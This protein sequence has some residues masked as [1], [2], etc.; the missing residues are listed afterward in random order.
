MSGRIRFAT[1]WVLAGLGAF[2]AAPA[3]AQEPPPVLTGSVLYRVTLLRAAGGKYDDLLAEVRRQVSATGGLAVRHSQGDQWDFVWLTPV[4]PASATG[5]AA[6][7]SPFSE[8]AVAWQEDLLVR[9]PALDALPGFLAAG[10]Y[11]FEMFDA[12]PGK[13]DELVRER[14]M[15]N[16]YLAGVGRP[17]NLIF[18]REF[19][20]AWDAFTIGAYRDWRHYAERELVTPA[21]A[22]AAAVAAG[23]S[24]EQAIGPYMRSL[25]LAHHDTLGGPIR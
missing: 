5:S 14:E 10:L 18:R 9:G 22:H 6:L 17:R 1:S 8:A 21:Q 25:I 13:L 7:T 19:G 23:F 4:Q 11:H 2:A 16:A 3:L 15:E 20:A 12:A 24:S